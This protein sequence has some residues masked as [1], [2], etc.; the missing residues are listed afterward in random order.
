[1][2]SNRLRI[3]LLLITGAVSAAAQNHTSTPWWTSPVVGDL[4]LTPQQTARIRGI[5][6]SYRNRLFDARNN[7]QK[8]EAD[9]EDLMNDPNV[10]VRA[11][12][13]VIQRLA[14]ARANVT[15]VFTEMSVDLRGVLTLDQWREL[16]KRWSE[17]Q[18]TQ[19]R[20]RHPGTA[21]TGASEQ[22]RLLGRRFNFL[23]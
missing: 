14:E 19:R 16:V 4:G 5:V 3:F 2:T 7:A 18:K 1:M 8:A 6:R 17:V 15:R 21:V 10:D 12:R 22:P 20:R 13:P 23:R 9:L 11:A